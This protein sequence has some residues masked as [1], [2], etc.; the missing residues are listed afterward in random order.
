[1][2]SFLTLLKVFLTIICHLNAILFYFIPIQNNK[3]CKTTFYSK[4]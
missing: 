3:T 1:M 4:L 2:T